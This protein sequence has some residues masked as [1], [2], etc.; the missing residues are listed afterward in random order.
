[1]HLISYSIKNI[2]R[3]VTW[4]IHI[5]RHIADTTTDY[6]EPKITAII[7][8]DILQKLKTATDMF[9]NT[10]KKFSFNI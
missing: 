9:T 5:L 3:P 10:K 4:N 2:T 6:F 7:H 1:M 8:S